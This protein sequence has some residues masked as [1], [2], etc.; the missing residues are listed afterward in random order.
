MPVAVLIRVSLSRAT[1]GAVICPACGVIECAPY[2]RRMLGRT[3]VQARAYI[4]TL[5]RSRWLVVSRFECPRC[6]RT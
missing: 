5:A 1:F 2:G 4:R 6:G 3:V